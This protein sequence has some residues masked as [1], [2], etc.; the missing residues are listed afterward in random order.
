MGKIEG[1][2]KAMKAILKA[3]NENID[4]VTPEGRVWLESKI[5]DMLEN[6]S[7]KED[8]ER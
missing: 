6:G 5:K 3:V 4:N 1:E 7:E 2:F 8:Q